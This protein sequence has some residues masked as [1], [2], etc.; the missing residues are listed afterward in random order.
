MKV[1]VEKTSSFQRV[2]KIEVPPETVGEEIENLYSKIS[3]TATHPGF[4]K[5]KVPRKILEKK[6]GKSIKMEAVENTVSSTLKKA[7]E[8]EHLVPLTDPDFGEVKFEDGPLSYEVTI[9]VEPSVELAEYKGIELKKPKLAVSDEDV[10]RVL[11]RLQLSHAKYTPADRPVEK[12]DIVII[13][14]ESFAQGKPIEGGKAENFPLEV[15]SD[16]FGEDFEK[17]LVGMKTGEE[18]RIVVNY[19]AD[20]RAP[21]LAGKEVTFAV[22]M[23]DVKLRELPE[24]N[25]DFAKDMGEYETLDELKKSVREN[26]LKDLKE[27]IE[28]FLR[29]QGLSKVVQGSKLE[30]PPKLK[31]RLAASVFEEEIGRLVQQGATK[32][33]ITQDRDRLAAFAQAEAERRLKI[34][35]VSDEIARRENLEVSDEELQ[36]SIEETIAEAENAEQRVRSYFNSEKVRDRYREQLRVR[37]ILE[38]IVNNAR[39]EEVDQVESAQR[40]EPTGE[41]A[42]APEADPTTDKDKEEG[43]TS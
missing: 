40:T 41:K 3:E 23:K 38:F 33:A 21:D 19:P 31:S 4:R 25:D 22:K 34:K 8:D 35:F 11:K 43:G 36:K 9:E 39:I 27:R 18:K 32:E 20:Y 7:L 16:A 10:D 12:G 29:E 30:I 6:F 37:K 42:A 17:Q 26:L 5:G 15:G 1:N 28:H 2:L 14:F 24:I 13:D